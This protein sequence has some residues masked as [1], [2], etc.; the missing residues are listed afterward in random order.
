VSEG[1]MMETVKRVWNEIWFQERTTTPLEVARIGIGLALLVHYGL[2]SSMLFTLWGADGWLPLKQLIADTA[3]SASK[4]SIFFY[5]TQDWQLALFHAIFLFCCAALMFGWRTSWVK[6]VVFIGHISYAQRNPGLTYGVDSIASSILL[7]LCLAPIGK[8]MSLDRVRE[9]AR[10]KRNNLDGRPPAYTSRWAFACRR[11]MQIQ[12]AILFF[13]SAL[14]K[15][16]ADGWW[17]GESLWQVFLTTD[18][19]SPMMLDLMASQFWLV[20]VTVYGVVLIE[21]AHPFL[22]WQKATRPFLL[23]GAVF[24]HLLFFFFLALHY[25]SFV[26]ILGHMS[27]LRHDWLTRLGEWWRARAGAMEMIYDGRCGFCVRSMR[28]FLAFDGTGQIKTRDFRVNPS[29]V[30]SDE[31][32]EKALHLV[33]PD[34]TALA[35]FEAYRY[36]VARVPGTWWMIPLFYVPVL[37]RS[38]GTLVYN[39]VAANRMKVS[40][41]LPSEVG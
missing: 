4:Q 2:A 9:V 7:L 41:M 26:M 10:F 16:R 18:Y 28:W 29:P 25:F 20:N 24:I 5:L 40:G 34:G 6:W 36:A 23:A 22:I 31:K 8:A 11:L 21:L 15:V 32:M 38:I 3:P 12:M 17:Q 27:F 35:G 1:A 33:L 14:H 30:I 37:S 13:F 19:Y 39:W